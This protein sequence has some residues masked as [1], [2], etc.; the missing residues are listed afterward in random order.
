MPRGCLRNCAGVGSFGSK[1]STR[2][3]SARI[4]QIHQFSAGSS[5][6]RGRC[7]CITRASRSGRDTR[8]V[9]EIGLAVSIFEAARSAADERG[10]GPLE[11]VTVVIGDLA[12]VEPELLEFAWQAVVGSG[13]DS[14]AR[15]IVDW[16][17]ARQDCP[18]CGEI[19]ERAAGSWLRLCPRCQGPL[20]VSGGDELELRT[21]VFG[22]TAAAAAGAR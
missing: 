17:R 9:H 4:I 10:G 2:H 7:I 11:S 6:P 13:P 1:G 18:A 12:A 21:V 14:G 3:P 19:A 15:L 8:P 22:E 16:R 20:A 5:L